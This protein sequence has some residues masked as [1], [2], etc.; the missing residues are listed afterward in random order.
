M[1]VKFFNK[2]ITLAEQEGNGIFSFLI[3]TIASLLPTLLSGKGLQ[4]KNKNK[5]NFFLK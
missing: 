2:Q 5:N 1:I 3:P 4:N